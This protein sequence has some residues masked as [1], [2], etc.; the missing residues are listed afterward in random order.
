VPNGL[1]VQYQVGDSF[2]GLGFACSL[3]LDGVE[4][5]AEVAGLVAEEVEELVAFP[6]PCFHQWLSA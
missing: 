5:R 4:A 1:Q 2:P 3:G 6:S